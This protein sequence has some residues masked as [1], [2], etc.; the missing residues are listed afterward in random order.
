MS[1]LL[2]L[3]TTLSMNLSVWLLIM[4]L[5]FG[6]NAPVLMQLLTPCDQ[7]LSPLVPKVRNPGDTS[8]FQDYTED[9][10]IFQIGAHNVHA[11]DFEDF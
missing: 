3:D 8:Q 1:A 5:H 4:A 10:S 6:F 9:Y 7:V 2:N 11:K